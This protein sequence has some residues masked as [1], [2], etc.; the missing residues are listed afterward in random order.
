MEEILSLLA[1]FQEKLNMLNDDFQKIK[2][3]THRLYKENEELKEENEN[4]KRL[5]FEQKAENEE[6]PEARE[7]YNN[8]AKLYE[9]GFHICHLNFGEKRDGECLF[10]MGLLDIQLDSEVEA[11]KVVQD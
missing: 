4:L 7:G 11:D 2:K 3:I 1:T 5:L 6:E 10:C 9:E 8:L